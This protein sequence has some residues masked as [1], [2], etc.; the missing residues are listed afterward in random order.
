[1]KRGDVAAIRASVHATSIRQRMRELSE[2]GSVMSRVFWSFEKRAS[3][4]PSGVV[5]KNSIGA[6]ITEWSMSLWMVDEALS[7][8]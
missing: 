2:T 5:S 4:R 6:P 7:S 3:T 8:A 1:M